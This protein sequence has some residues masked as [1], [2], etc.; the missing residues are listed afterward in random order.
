[1]MLLINHIISS[2][3]LKNRNQRR[4]T[5]RFWSQKTIPGQTAFEDE[6]GSLLT[7]VSPV[8]F[9]SFVSTAASLDGD[10]CEAILS[11]IIPVAVA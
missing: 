1:M 7:A 11:A 5:A 4:L 8:V 2:E 9:S 6:C 10:Q 3:T